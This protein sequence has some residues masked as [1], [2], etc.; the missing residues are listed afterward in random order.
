MP[1][2]LVTLA[3]GV[4]SMPVLRTVLVGHGSRQAAICALLAAT[5]LDWVDGPLARRLGP[6]PYGAWLDIEV[7]SWLTLTTACAGVR[8]R[9]LPAV[10]LAPPLARYVFARGPANDHRPWHRMAGR[11]QMAVLLAAVSAVP[12]PPSL[13]L[14]A[15]AVQL[16][17][18]IDIARRRTRAGR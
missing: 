11:A 16:A 6:T 8:L 14:T 15:A 18:L 3:R 13:A 1:A 5:V 4:L 2:D 17:A 9:R 7:D 10:C 12:V